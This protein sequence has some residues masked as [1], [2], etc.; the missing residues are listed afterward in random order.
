VSLEYLDLRERKFHSEESNN[1]YSPLYI[2]RDIK[3]RTCNTHEGNKKLLPRILK[4]GN[5]KLV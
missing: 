1:A 5:F 4:E 3:S 2:I